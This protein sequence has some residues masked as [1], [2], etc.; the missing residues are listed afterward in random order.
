IVASRLVERFHRPAVVIALQGGQGRG[1]GRSIAAYDLHAGLGEAAAHLLGFGGHKM[2]AGLQI[3]ADR[4]EPF[5][6][7][8][9]AH[10]GGLLRPGDLRAHENVDAV[11][12]GGALTLETAEELER[13]GPFGAGNPAP[14]LLAP[15]AGIEHVTAMGEERKHARFSLV[16]GGARARGVAF[17][18]SQRSL[19]AAGARPQDVAVSLER[20]RW[21]G[22][23]EARVVLEG[24][25]PSPP[26][27]VRN[28][29]EGE[30]W[31][32]I[33]AELAG[34][35]KQWWSTAGAD[36][37]HTRAGEGDRLICERHGE[38]L[39]GVAGDLLTSGGEV[40]LV[41][42][43]AARRRAGL[44][45]S[46]AGMAPRGLAVTTWSA[47]GANP[48]LAEPFTHLLAVDPPPV[49]AGVE[50]LR[51]A[52]GE[53]TAH[54]AWGPAET[55]FALGYWRLQLGVRAELTALWRSLAKQ[56]G[57]DGPELDA[58]LGGPGSHPREGALA[59]RLLRVL[60]E[61]G[62]LEVDVG[63]REVLVASRKRTS[64]EHSLAYRAYAGRLAAAE[65]YLGAPS[66]PPLAVRA[67]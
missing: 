11:I 1:S 60:A 66:A 12:P 65:R 48:G 23:V 18:R 42:A 62:L 33:A 29:G 13:L 64:L 22:T 19:A 26:G 25:S 16:G 35:P 27:R 45:S 31:E 9:A 4:V 52:P 46:I 21:N 40:L 32:E 56:G 17:R 30:L 53:G 28:V 7:A 43:D 58:A 44:E 3:E 38:G 67:S 24:L 36:D 54:L 47:L 51:A 63:S 59:G 15:A 55:A 61:I 5:R 39:A 10:A 20:N 14:R 6:R 34:D 50:R 57:L 37:R 2:A 41:V 8:L 49:Q